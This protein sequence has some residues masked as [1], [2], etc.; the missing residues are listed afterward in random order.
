MPKALISLDRRI[1]KVNDAIKDWQNGRKPKSSCYELNTHATLDRM[2]AEGKSGYIVFLGYPKT[3]FVYHVYGIVGT[4]RI[5]PF[6]DKFM[7]SKEFSKLSILKRIKLSEN[8]AKRSV[9]GD[10][11][12]TARIME[13][14]DKV[15]KL[16]IAIKE[17]FPFYR[18]KD[19]KFI[20]R[21]D[22]GGF[23]IKCTS[24]REIKKWLERNMDRFDIINV[25]FLSNNNLFV[26]M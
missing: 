3:G 7:N 6:V 10:L 9:S 13:E 11:R 18:W 19:I 4:E 25:S 5:D 15:K 21:H 12:V 16:K 14:T 23:E 8:V 1:D 22:I 2:Q 26:W 17:N 20:S 24:C